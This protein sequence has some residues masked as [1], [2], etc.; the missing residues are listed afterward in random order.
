[1]AQLSRTKK[2]EELRNKLDEQTTAAQ[3]KSE[4]PVKYARLSR[5]EHAQLSH[6]NQPVHSHKENKVNV[7][8]KASSP[9]IDHLL[10]EVKQYNID[11]GNRYTGDTQ[12]NILKQLDGNTIQRRN[13]HFVPMDQ[14]EEQLGSTMKMSTTEFHQDTVDG[15]QTY[16]PNQ[17]LTRMNPVN[18][19]PME[20]SPFSNIKE[21]V[22]SKPE[23]DQI[24]LGSKDILADDTADLDQLNI[25]GSSDEE[26]NSEFDRTGSQPKVR[27]KV[28]QKKTKKNKK[29][30]ISSDMPSAQ[31]RMSAKDI[32]ENE[33]QTQGSKSGMILNIILGVLIVLLLASIGAMVY[34]I[35][36]MGSL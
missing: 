17:K 12:I 34:F 30:N 2:Y 16:M 22:E 29:G 20:N 9:V 5:V 4:Q 11:C 25:F 24:V 21:E 14:D 23:Q 32:D 18:V 33:S 15:I 7:N 10:D 35:M 36:N 6:A 3:T 13:Q 19:P 27:R 28:K 8:E 31:M 26:I 1:M